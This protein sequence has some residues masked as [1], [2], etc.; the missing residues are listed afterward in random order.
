VI[1]ASRDGLPL[2]LFNDEVRLAV[3]KLDTNRAATLPASA[4]DELS[5]AEHKKA[6]CLGQDTYKMAD[7]YKIV[8]AYYA[9]TEAI[10]AGLPPGT[11]HEEVYRALDRL[12]DEE[13]LMSPDQGD[14]R[15]AARIALRDRRASE[16]EKC[17]A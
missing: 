17:A 4:D 9:A 3:D 5:P 13:A 6:A 7:Y 12:R 1:E 8:D 2:Q 14:Q 15:Y 16:L 11:P 10:A